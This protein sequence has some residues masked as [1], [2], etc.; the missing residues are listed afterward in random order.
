M[1]ANPSHHELKKNM[2]SQILMVQIQIFLIFF[3]EVGNLLNHEPKKPCLFY[4]QKFKTFNNV[5]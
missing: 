5:I 4:P 3:L 2:I 1:A